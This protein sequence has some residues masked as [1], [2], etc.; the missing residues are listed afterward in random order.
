MQLGSIRVTSR[1]PWSRFMAT[2]ALLLACSISSSAPADDGWQT[3]GTGI[4]KKTI[5]L[6]SFDLYVMRHEMRGPL[7]ARSRRKVIEADQDKRFVW[8]FLRDI[9]CD[10]MKSALR[11]RF[12]SNGYRVQADINSFVGS[13]SGAEAKKDAIVTVVYDSSAKVTTISIGGLGRASLSGTE[14][15][16]AVWSLWLGNTDQPELGDALVANLKQ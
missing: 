1:S 13:C 16:R 8:R 15:M 12:E 6:L 2:L 10:K 14:A 11:E 3:T 4:R 7:P 5:L 9:P